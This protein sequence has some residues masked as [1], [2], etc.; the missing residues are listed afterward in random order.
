MNNMFRIIL[1]VQLCWLATSSVYGLDC[2]PEE[3]HYCVMSSCISGGYTLDLYVPAMLSGVELPID[4]SNLE[5]FGTGCSPSLLLVSDQDGNFVYQ[6]RSEG[7]R[8]VDEEPWRNVRLE[9]FEWQGNAIE[10]TH[11]FQ[12]SSEFA[13]L[14]IW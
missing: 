8:F 13:Y 9:V 1:A 5:W 4:T 14:G 6:Y 7:L 3:N 2:D 12:T 10:Q 11:K